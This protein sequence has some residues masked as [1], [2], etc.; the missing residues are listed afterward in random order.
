MGLFT[1]NIIIAQSLL[2]KAKG[3]GVC[4]CMQ[5]KMKS[6][7]KRHDIIPRQSAASAT[8]FVSAQTPQAG[9]KH[10]CVCLACSA[11]R[12]TLFFF[13]PPT[14]CLRVMNHRASSCERQG[15]S[16]GKYP[17]SGGW[18]C[19]AFCF[20]RDEEPRVDKDNEGRK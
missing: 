19:C 6:P 11:A 1:V 8:S 17:T 13:F 12:V 20:F 16:G 4:A 9:E 18:S 10:T 2:L 3:V 14:N 7:N 5:V 15:L